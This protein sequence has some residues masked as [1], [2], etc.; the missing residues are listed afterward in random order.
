MAGR[1]AGVGLWKPAND[2]D[3]TDASDPI[4]LLWRGLAPLGTPLLSSKSALPDLLF[5]VALV[6]LNKPVAMPSN[7]ELQKMMSKTRNTEK[8]PPILSENYI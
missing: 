5:S 3:E 8:A 4:Y 2:M 6:K 7:P 1:G